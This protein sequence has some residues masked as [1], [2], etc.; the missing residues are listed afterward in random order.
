MSS[1]K[2]LTFDIG[3]TVFD[4]KSAVIEAV[5]TMAQKHKV[6]VDAESFAMDWRLKKFE[7]LSQMRAGK[8]SNMNVDGLIRLGVEQL[9]STYPQLALP[10]D[11]FEELS[12]AWH[13]MKVWPDFPDAL[14]QLRE[15]YYVAVLTILSFLIAVDCSRLNG[16]CWDGIMS[17]EFLGHYKPDAA[18]YQAGCK[19]LNLNPDQVMMVASHP[20][21]LIAASKAGMKTAFVQPKSNEPDFPGFSS[22][23]DVNQFNVVAD[24]F[25]DLAEQ[26]CKD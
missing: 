22:D 1:V 8:I 11:D 9:S 7:L 12:Q 19:L 6:E 20:A 26:L 21:D 18:A 17:C 3:G 14:I 24:D 16:I 23:T 25:G 2:A 13:R 5:N 10:D 15:R 4:W